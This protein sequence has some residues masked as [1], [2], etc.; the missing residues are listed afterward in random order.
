MEF[1]PI[2]DRDPWA[3]EVDGHISWD[4]SPDPSI[5]RA[6]REVYSATCPDT[7]VE[8]VLK[9]DH[10][11]ARIVD[12]GLREKICCDLAQELGVPTPGALLYKGD[13]KQGVAVRRLHGGVSF[14]MWKQTFKN[15]FPRGQ[16][17]SIARANYPLSMIGFDW[18]V[19]NSDRNNLG[20]ILVIGDIGNPTFVPIDFG[21]TLGTTE[22]PWSVPQ[23]RW[24]YCH[25]YGLPYPAW[26]ILD[27]SSRNSIYG[28]CDKLSQLPDDLIRRIINRA[29]TYYTV[30]LA[31]RPADIEKRL[32]ERKEKAR[33]WISKN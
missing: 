21:N 24:D 2:V 9:L 1:D 12:A 17:V 29:T 10:A 19:G 4:V 20:N 26:L 30:N 8:A 18:Y 5:K 23:Y 16:F 11:E 33:E 6:T 3:D 31:T 28:F 27:E 32:I 13:A 15:M 25:G 7:G 14:I 22:M